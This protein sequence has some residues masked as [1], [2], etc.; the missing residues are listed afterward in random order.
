MKIG[1]TVTSDDPLIDPSCTYVELA[2]YVIGFF[3]ENYW[4]SRNEPIKCKANQRGR[5]LTLTERS[6]PYLL[7][8]Y[9]Q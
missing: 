5:Y 2:P 8:S 7:R 9:L 6:N 1:I 4:A 3:S